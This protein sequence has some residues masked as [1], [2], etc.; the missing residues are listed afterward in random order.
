MRQNF[1]CCKIVRYSPARYFLGGI[2]KATPKM[3]CARTQRPFFSSTYRH[4]LKILTEVFSLTTLKGL[5]KLNDVF[6]QFILLQAKD[7]FYLNTRDFY[8]FPLF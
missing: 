7:K 6:V 5:V 2:T 4:Y 8:K 1:S 3:Y